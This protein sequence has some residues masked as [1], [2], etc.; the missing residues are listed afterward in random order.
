[1]HIFITAL[2]VAAGVAVLAALIIGLNKF[3]DYERRQYWETGKYTGRRTRIYGPGLRGWGAQSAG[4]GGAGFVGIHDH[5][6]TG[7][8]SGG[9]DSGCGGAGGCGGGGCGGG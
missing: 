3:R 5:G 8:D 2:I 1:M 7:G 9:G 6:V 4:L